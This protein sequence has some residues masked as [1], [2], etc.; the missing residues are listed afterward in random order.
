MNRNILYYTVG[1]L[2]AVL[3]CNTEGLQAQGV[4]I[5]ETN[6]PPDPSAMLDVQSLTK[7]MLIPRMSGGQRVGIAAPANGLIVYQTANTATT[8]RGFWYY[9]APQS[10]WIHLGRGELTGTAQQP[11]TL[12]NSTMS[13]VIVDPIVS[14]G[15]TA[16]GQST[17]FWGILPG[18]GASPPP[19]TVLVSAE[20]TV[21][22]TP[23]DITDYCV[24]FTGVCNT[25]IRPEFV[26]IF[27]PAPDMNIGNF[28]VAS[29][30]PYLAAFYHLNCTG[31]Y[32]SNHHYSPYNGVLPVLSG[33][34]NAL[35]IDFCNDGPGAGELAFA[36]K[37][38]N[39]GFNYSFTFFVDLNQ[40]GDFDDPNEMVASFPDRPPS[41]AQY[42]IFSDYLINPPWVVHPG[43]QVPNT[44]AE[45]MTKLRVITHRAA[46]T[47]E[48]PCYGGNNNMFI[49]DFDMEILCTGELPLYPSDLNWCNVD[50][51]TPM[52]AR[53]SCFDKNGTPANTKY[54][55]KIVPHN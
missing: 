9:D 11:S 42:F 54:H 19:P 21:V 10:E 2:L 29:T 45:G 12:V 27:H 40:D 25:A 17:L 35:S 51:V 28:N 53:I 38:P 14:G 26:R 7:G 24:P 46:N 1:F 4:S 22:N 52:Q 16:V 30:L 44:A 50:D 6:S 15:D 47:V 31:V 37:R 5:S 43:V 23:P 49:Y 36:I 8:R 13:G 39:N 34:N 32:D 18:A 20:Y 55:F 41:V 3:V 48:N 33:K